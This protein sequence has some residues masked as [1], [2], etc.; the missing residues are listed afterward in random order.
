L[1]VLPQAPVGYCSVIIKSLSNKQIA[2]ERLEGF[3]PTQITCR[4]IGNF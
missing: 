1:L 2:I 3:L 4:D